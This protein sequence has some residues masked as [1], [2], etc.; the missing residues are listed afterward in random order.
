[1][2]CLPPV[3]LPPPV[4]PTP[5]L[6]PAPIKAAAHL[7]VTAVCGHFS[8]LTLASQQGLTRLV[9]LS[10]KPISF[11]LAPRDHPLHGPGVTLSLA[12]GSASS[13]ALSSPQPLNGQGSPSP[14]LFLGSALCGPGP[15]P[16]P[17]FSATQPAG[18]H[19]SISGWHLSCLPDCVCTSSTHGYPGVSS[20]ATSTGN[21]EK[22]IFLPLVF[23]TS[24]RGTIY[25][26][27]CSNPKS[28]HLLW[29]SPLLCT[30]QTHCGCWLILPV[31]Y[32]EC[33]CFLALAL[34]SP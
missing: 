22:L 8:G 19:I 33:V 29:F 15:H 7:Q 16:G 26:P 32:Q 12:S 11:L 6:Q 9:P 17:G 23:P 14:A 10:L 13:A 28:R 4:S 24:G 3:S 20:V 1:M 21:K 31:V 2:L 30:D 27:S 25:L 34:P 18:S 5:P